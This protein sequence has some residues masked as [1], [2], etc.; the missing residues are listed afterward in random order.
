M[1]FNF[2]WNLFPHRETT[3]NNNY[4]KKVKL[5]GKIPLSIEFKKDYRI[6]S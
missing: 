4:K 5:F 3:D 6:V 2:S 1:H